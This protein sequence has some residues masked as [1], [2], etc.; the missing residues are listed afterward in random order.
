MDQHQQTFLQ[1]A[2]EL[3]DD[4]QAA[5]LELEESPDSRDLIARIFRD[6]HTIKGSGNMFGF[7]AIGAFAHE[8]ET[9]LD[10]LR[11]G[12]IQASQELIDLVLA[13]A[14]QIRGLLRNPEGE[15]PAD[16]AENGRLLIGELQGFLREGGPAAGPAA[17]QAGTGPSS[18]KSSEDVTYRVSIRPKS[19]LFRNGTNPIPL[20]AELRDLGFSHVFCHVD[21]IPPIESLDPE[22]CYTH[23]DV[24]LTTHQGRDAIEGVF[25]FVED[26]CDIEITPIESSESWEGPV[27]PRLGEILVQRGVLTQEE[28]LAVL[29]RQKRLGQLL[30]E[31]NKLPQGVVD[32]ALV[33]QTH[34]REL[35]DRRKQTET[36]ATVRVPAHRLDHLIDLAG[37]LVTVQA[38]LSRAALEI[39]NPELTVIAEIVERLTSE[40]RDNSM[41]IRMVPIGTTFG[42]FKRLVRDLSKELS[43]QVLLTTDGAET[44]LDKTVIERLN[45]PLVHII[46]NCIDHGIESPEAR[47]AK[48]KPR[49][50]KIHLAAVHAGAHVVVSVS[51]DGAG[52]DANRLR[53]KAIQQGLVPAGAELSERES[54][55]LIFLPGFSTAK[56]VTTVSGRGVGMD[57]V[58][59]NVE[60]LRGTVEIAS[61]LGAGTTVSLRLPLTLAIIDGLL[62]EV[63]SSRYVMPLSVVDECVELPREEV[64]RAHGKHIVNLRGELVPYIRLREM[65]GAAGA[66]PEI[67]QVAITHIRGQRLGFV[68]DHVVGQHQTV[69]KTLGKVYRGSREF[70]GAT[71]LPDGTVGL[72]LDIQKLAEIAEEED[73]RQDGR[74]T[75]PSIAPAATI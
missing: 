65:F 53:E 15:L 54:F 31:D 7:D 1:E 39:D 44:E 69:I 34:I 71:I 21:Q 18:G 63:G 4:L 20:L 12:E 14:D 23:W 3:L 48:G 2:G 33:E 64:K 38:R 16:L 37:E 46:R 10:K 55:N 40:L 8:L 68:V 74:R 52:L 25:I 13:S 72:I 36:A 66:M 42:Q 57:V 60:M 62:V 47:A 22:I 45:D 49:Q 32:S 24:I 50:G 58:R 51:D 43:K 28:L 5:L 27:T 70:S 41:G 61:E 59:K 19:E 35:Q 67:E 73:E 75:P 26:L 17:E 29:S 56:A 9:V 11:N 30:V 6:V